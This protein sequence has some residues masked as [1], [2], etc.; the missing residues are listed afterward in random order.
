[1]YRIYQLEEV[2]HENL[3]PEKS[4]EVQTAGGKRKSYNPDH[5]DGE[6]VGGDKAA[7]KKPRRKKAKKGV[8][9]TV[10]RGVVGVGEDASAEIDKGSQGQKEGNAP[11][12]GQGGDAEGLK[13]KEPDAAGERAGDEAEPPQ[14]KRRRKRR[15]RIG[16]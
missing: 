13:G 8:T 1:M 9:E 12:I 14:V 2:I 6:A 5:D 11:T 10:V 4:R 16:F 3:R 7:A 15:I